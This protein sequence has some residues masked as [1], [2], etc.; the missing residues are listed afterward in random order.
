MASTGG[1]VLFGHTKPSK[2]GVQAIKDKVKTK[3]ERANH[4]PA[5]S[6]KEDL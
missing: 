5:R 6:I 2:K 4:F 1:L 3:K